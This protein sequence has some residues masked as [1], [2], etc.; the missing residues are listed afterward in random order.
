MNTV[1]EFHV[2]LPQETVSEGFAQGPY[3]AA[4]AGIEPMTLRTKDS[5]NAAPRTNQLLLLLLLLQPTW[6]AS[7]VNGHAGRIR[8]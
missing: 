5:T 3:V 1:P 7:N 8:V 2:K 6:V 4:T